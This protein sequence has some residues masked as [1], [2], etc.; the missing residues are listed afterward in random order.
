M[1]SPLQSKPAR[2]AMPPHAVPS[3]CVGLWFASSLSFS[4]T[5]SMRSALSHSMPESVIAMWIESSP[6]VSRHA[7]STDMPDGLPFSADRS[8]VAT[9]GVKP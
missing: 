8:D 2:A 7:R 9:L 4:H 6:M 5:F 1:P 3:A